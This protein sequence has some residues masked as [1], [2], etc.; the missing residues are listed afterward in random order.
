MKNDLNKSK[1][2][3]FEENE[4]DYINLNKTIPKGWVDID[5]YVPN[6]K[7]EDL[8]NPVTSCRVRYKDGNEG[9]ITFGY[10]TTWYDK[11][12]MLG[13]THWYNE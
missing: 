5:E 4:M 1:N 10:Q 6:L 8:L 2:I 11:A 13:I 3:I 7:T 12:K 9:T